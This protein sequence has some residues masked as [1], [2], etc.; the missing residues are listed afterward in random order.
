MDVDWSTPYSDPGATAFDPIAGNLTARI[1]RSS[2]VNTAIP[3]SYAVSY[4]VIDDAG[5]AAHKTR[6]VRVLPNP[7]AP[8]LPVSHTLGVIA[9]GVVFLLRIRR[10]RNNFG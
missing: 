10:L 5:N 6:T 4:D 9:V 2:N 1:V 3:G 7:N 8:V